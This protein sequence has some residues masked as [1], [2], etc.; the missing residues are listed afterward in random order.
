[1]ENKDTMAN[2]TS[3]F[4]NFPLARN[5]LQQNS[6]STNII[7]AIN[8]LLSMYHPDDGIVAYERVLKTVLVLCENFESNIQQQIISIIP[9]PKGASNEAIRDVIY[10]ITGLIRTTNSMT[11]CQKYDCY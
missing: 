1:M 2:A 7:N 9:L 4:E 3:A 6:K 11:T 10:K 8:R 5:V